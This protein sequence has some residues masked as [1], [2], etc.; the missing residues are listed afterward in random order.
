MTS[1]IRETVEKSG[2]QNA[3]GYF[4]KPLGRTSVIS[5]TIPPYVLYGEQYNARRQT[6]KTRRS[7]APSHAPRKGN[8]RRFGKSGHWMAE[9][10]D[11]GRTGVSHLDAQ[12]ARVK[13]VGG[14]SA[15]T[16]RVLYEIATELDAAGQ[17]RDGNEDDSKSDGE[18]A[19]DVFEQFC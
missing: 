3:H 4:G 9:C 5:F 11:R 14:G 16:A 17:E 7:A 8:C 6:Q 2:E 10:P 13:D 1:W 12:R 15:G 19:L 18:E